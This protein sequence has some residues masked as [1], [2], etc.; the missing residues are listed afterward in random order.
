M[1]QPTFLPKSVLPV[2]LDLPSLTLLG[3][4][5]GGSLGHASEKGQ[6]TSDRLQTLDPACTSFLPASMTTVTNK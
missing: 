1:I 5:S 3:N 6:H 2:F 4:E